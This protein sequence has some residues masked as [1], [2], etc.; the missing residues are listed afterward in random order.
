MSTSNLSRNPSLFECFAIRNPYR[1]H[2]RAQ[3]TTYTVDATGRKCCRAMFAASTCYACAVGMVGLFSVFN[4]GSLVQMAVVCLTA[5]VAGPVFLLPLAYLSSK[6]GKLIP[7]EQT[8]ASIT[9]FPAAP[10]SSQSTSE[11]SQLPLA[12]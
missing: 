5:I 8:A 3:G 4:G 7:I 2:C 9:D 10:T 11:S 12:G 6:Y 1:Y